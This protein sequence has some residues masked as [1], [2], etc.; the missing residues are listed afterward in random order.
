MVD[1]QRTLES[2]LEGE[3]LFD[4]FSRGRYSTDA[5]IY[6][7]MPIGVV[8]PRTAQDALRAVEIAAEA[9]VAIL[10]RGGGTSQCGQAIGDALVIDNSK[11][12]RGVDELCAQ[13]QSIWVEPGVVLDHLNA[14]LKPHGLWYPVDVSTAGQ[15]TIGGMTANNSCGARSIVYGNMVHNVLAVDAWLSSGD[16]MTFGVVEGTAE[17]SARYRQLVEQVRALY[18]RE[19][20]EIALRVPKVQRRVAGYNLDMAS[21]DAFNMAHLLVGSEGTLG[22]FK[23]IKLQLAA[24]PQN[25]VLGVVH[26]PT[27]FQSM[28]AT[29][30]IVELGPAAVELVDRTMIE[31]SRQNDAFRPIVEKS[32]KGD[33]DAVLLVEFA[34]D[35][36]SEQQRKLDQLCELLGDLK[37]PDAVVRIEDSALQRDVWNVRKAGLNIMMS[38]KGDG[39]PVSFIEDCAVPLEHL[40]DYTARLNDVFGKHD[41]QGT[42]YAHASVGCLHVRPVLNMREEIGA[43]K[44]RAIAEEACAL[45]QEYKGSYSGEHGDGLVRSEWIERLYGTQLTAAFA[46]LKRAFDPRGLMNPGKIV[47]PSQMDDRSLFRFKPDYQ[48]MTPK[49][50]LDWSGHEIGEH[51]KGRG[52]AA[53]TEM[54]NNNGHCRKFDAGTM[55]PSYRV[56]K[57][58]RDSTRGRANALR[59]ALAGQLGPDA[60]TSP[61]MYQTMELCVSC[62]GCKRECPTGVDM[63]AMKV[64]FLHQ[65]YARRKRPIKDRL[66]ASL[67]RN[68]P[69]LSRFSRLLN[70]RNKFAF[71][72]KIG[73]KALGLSAQRQLPKWHS[74]FFRGQSEVPAR[75]TGP[76]LVLLADTFNRWFEPE[77]MRAAIEVLHKAGYRIVVPDAGPGRRPLCCG[78]T[79]LASG[80]IEEARDEARRTL[81]VLKP[82]LERNVPVVGLEPSCLLGMRDEFA[83]ML[84]GNDTRKL[85]KL[86]YTFE[87]FLANEADA[88]RLTLDLRATRFREALV[89]GH[90][91][92]KAFDVMPAVVRLLRMIPGLKVETVQSS[93]CGM[94]GAFGYDARNLEISRQMAEASLLPAVRSAGEDTVVIADGTSC[95][96]QIM[97][98]SERKALHVAR[99]LAES[100]AP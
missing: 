27:F 82:Y 44:M 67:P 13:D 99:L 49:T 33:P 50:G 84:P 69:T 87:E 7:I 22:Y 31:L 6:Q 70:L 40:A 53:A 57:S 32:I 60:L 36:L 15:A 30:H 66:I 64:E 58:E 39:K 20:D 91:H 26:F 28:D 68:A 45:V 88:G 25:K 83:K 46:E 85:A 56:T 97:D 96:H 95:R 10:P 17:G 35:E 48:T 77:N 63:A 98:F 12:L 51:N 19:R 9:G 90:C 80:M 24:L 23:R 72:A 71:V 81:E 61:D 52:F 62:K 29:Q 65:Y 59:L 79:Y 34:G 38:M 100:A 4:E 93:C 76:Q 2:E 21:A 1:L 92:Q 41:A 86:S 8:V 11:H 47:A 3:V 74:D 43:K 16:C 14:R 78:R 89:H 54:C 37:L 42:F 18:Q 75:D 55:C 5:S 94:A 73:E